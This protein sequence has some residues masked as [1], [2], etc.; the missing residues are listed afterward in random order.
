MINI[1]SKLRK[2]EGQQMEAHDYKGTSSF[3]LK[4]N[5]VPHAHFL[6][7]LV[8]HELTLI[9]LEANLPPAGP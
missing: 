3:G 2:I 9:S 5:I 6:N 1:I 4:S 8:V 7:D